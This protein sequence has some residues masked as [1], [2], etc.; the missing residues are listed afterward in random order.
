MSS[1]PVSCEIRYRV[2]PTRIA[3]FE[4]YAQI[5][6]KLIERH[7]G[8]HHGYFM[9]REKPADAKLSFVGMGNEGAADV[10]IALFTFPN[11]EADARYREQVA[12]DPEGVDANARFGDA[13]PFLGYERIFLTPLSRPA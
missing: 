10:A 3:E 2:D 4:A 9:P 1:S 12:M 13:P 7:G 5:W 6:I 8:L 11:E